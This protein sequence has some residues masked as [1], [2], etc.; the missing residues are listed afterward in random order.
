MAS[1]LN[2]IGP[3]EQKIFEGAAIAHNRAGVPILPHTEQGTAAMM[4]ID[5]LERSGVKPSS[6]VISHLDANLML[7]I[8]AR[9]F[10]V[11]YLSNMILHFDGNQRRIP[12]RT[13]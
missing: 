9:F 7:P 13:C 6:I 10:R 12:L 1:E 11:E 4:Q 5:L 3:R 2:A 8:T